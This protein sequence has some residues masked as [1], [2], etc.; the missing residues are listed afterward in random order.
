MIRREREEMRHKIKDEV[1]LWH[2]VAM[3][4]TIVMPCVLKFPE[5]A[6]VCF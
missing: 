5:F 1:M 2:F 4:I 6:V 3:N